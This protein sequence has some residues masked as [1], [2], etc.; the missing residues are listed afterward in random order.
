MGAR[1]APA[2]RSSSVEAASVTP[3]CSAVSID[4]RAAGRL[5]AASVARSHE[6][7]WSNGSTSSEVI[8]DLAGAPMSPRTNTRS[9]TST[10]FTAVI[11]SGVGVGGEGNGARVAGHRGDGEAMDGGHETIRVV[12]MHRT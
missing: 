7:C 1:S 3:G 8:A 2:A 10:R 6:A 4:H 11:P 12:A 9:S 5:P